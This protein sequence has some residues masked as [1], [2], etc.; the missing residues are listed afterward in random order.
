[1]PFTRQELE[2]MNAV[3]KNHSNSNS[4]SSAGS[5][6]ECSGVVSRS[7]RWKAEG[8]AIDRSIADLNRK[9]RNIEILGWHINNAQDQR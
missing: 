8:E 1:M 5:I 2:T 6:A 9:I 4:A 7:D 3:N